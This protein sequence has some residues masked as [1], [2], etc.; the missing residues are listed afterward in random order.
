MQILARTSE[1]NVSFAVLPKYTKDITIID[2]C[3]FKSRLVLQ[4]QFWKNQSIFVISIIIY[5]LG[6]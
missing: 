3:D 1:N 2:F 6:D 4:Q 5:R